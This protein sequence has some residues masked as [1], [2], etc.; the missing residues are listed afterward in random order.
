MK[1]LDKKYIWVALMLFAIIM[2]YYFLRVH[3]LAFFK[4]IFESNFVYWV[5]GACSFILSLIHKMKFQNEIAKENVSFMDFK[6]VF[7]V[8]IN[9]AMIVT[10]F[11]LSKGLFL[12]HFFGGDYFR[13]FSEVEMALLTAVVAYVLYISTIQLKKLTIEAFKIRSTEKVEP[14]KDDGQA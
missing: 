10:A 11:S 1:N 13:N 6:D 12:Q 7:E 4:W 2:P 5:L 8:L 9:P 14:K 3:Y